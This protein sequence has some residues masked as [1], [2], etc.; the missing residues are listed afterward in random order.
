MDNENMIYKKALV[1]FDEQT[2]IH[3]TLSNG[4]FYNG[5]LFEITK[6]YLV[7]HD[8]GVGRKKVFLFEIKN[9]DEF[10]EVGR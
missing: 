5:R 4:T 1:F 2:I 6:N 7:I 8:R 3:L 10:L 9:I